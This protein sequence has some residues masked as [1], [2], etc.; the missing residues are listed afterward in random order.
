MGEK[1]LRWKSHQQNLYA[2]LYCYYSNQEMVDTT[3]VFKD[4]EIKAHGIILSA[5]SRFFRN[6]LNTNESEHKKSIIFESTPKK[7]MEYLLEFLYTG[8]VAVPVRALKKV[9]D[10]ARQYEVRGIRTSNI[11][12]N[13]SLQILENGSDKISSPEERDATLENI[14]QN[15]SSSLVRRYRPNLRKNPISPK[16]NGNVESSPIAS[17]SP[18]YARILNTSRESNISTS[19][20]STNGQDIEL[21]PRKEHSGSGK[22]SRIASTSRENIQGHREKNVPMHDLVDSDD[23]DSTYIREPQE[24]CTSTIAKNPE[25]GQEESDDAVEVV[26][27]TCDQVVTLST[28]SPTGLSKDLCQEEV[29]TSNNKNNTKQKRCEN[30]LS[31]DDEEELVIKKSKR[32]KKHIS[33]NKCSS[34]AQ[35]PSSTHTEGVAKRISGK[36]K[37]KKYEKL[38]CERPTHEVNEFCVLCFKFFK[39]TVQ[40]NTRNHIQRSPFYL[41]IHF[42]VFWLL[43]VLYKM[44]SLSTFL[45]HL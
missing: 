23:S 15:S 11:D 12:A 10:A 29:S 27:M 41:F 30:F 40:L 45:D 9:L 2:N 42:S 33:H 32:K 26:N 14:E 39:N 36:R 34:K 7:I 20:N 18:K 28:L 43:V 21:L 6:I 24:P 38:I 13:S 17:K 22:Y 16:R 19:P 35:N 44:Y 1:L 25:R 8:Q 31:T 37:T 5:G 3:L 4:G